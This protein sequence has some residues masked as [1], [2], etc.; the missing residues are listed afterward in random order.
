MYEAIAVRVLDL[1]KVLLFKRK[2]SDVFKDSVQINQIAGE[3]VSSDLS[4]D[5]FFLIMA[6]NGGFKLLPHGFK[7]WSIIDGRVQEW[8]MKNFKLSNYR[9][10]VASLEY[11]HLFASIVEQKKYDVNIKN[12]RDGDMKTHMNF[13]KVKHYRFFLLKKSKNAIWVAAVGTNADN[14]KLDSVQHN[15]VLGIAVNKVQNIIK[16]Y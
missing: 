15:H 7:Y 5:C 13:E 8:I 14:E 4:I 2:P 6:H 1:F 10:I 11:L 3:M 16:R 12:L 9:N